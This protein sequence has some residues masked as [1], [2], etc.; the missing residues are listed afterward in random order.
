MEIKAFFDKA[1]STLTYV[2]YDGASRDAVI[3]DPVLDFD[4]ASGRMSRS[5]AEEVLAFVRA[6]RLNVRMVLETHAHADH[7]S[8]SQILRE[9]L[10]GVTLAVGEGITAVQRRFKPVYGLPESFPTDGSQFDR[11]LKAG[12]LVEAGALRFEVRPTP[13]HTEACSSYRFGDNVFTGDALFMPD[14]G[15]GRCDFPGGSAE[16]LFASVTQQLFTLPGETRLFTGH[17]Y[18]PG[19]RGVE[20]ESSVAEQKH[21]NVQLNAQT[22][23]EE[24]I[25]FRSQR[26][27]TLAAPKLLHPSVQVNIDGGRIPPPET[28]GT[29]YVKV[30][31]TW[32][33]A[34]DRKD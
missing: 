11:L 16:N 3:I 15:T 31:L 19:G 2:A 6:T 1:T 33:T 23:R 26:D 8:S 22:K 12:E 7:L 9:A 24:F 21:G 25:A 30:P 32:A 14:Y 17:D 20:F 13:G 27:Q 4:S 28:N 5:S 29:S 10:P 34:A 18:Q